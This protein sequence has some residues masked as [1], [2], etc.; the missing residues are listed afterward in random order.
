MK[1][2]GGLEVDG[3]LQVIAINYFN[4]RLIPIKIINHCTAL[5]CYVIFY[6]EGRFWPSY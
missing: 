2:E 6:M 3:K 1:G 5:I 4:R